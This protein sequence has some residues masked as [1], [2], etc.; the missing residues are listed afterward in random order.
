MN[1]TTSF[2][3]A[4]VNALPLGDGRLY[5]GGYFSFINGQPREHVG[6]VNATNGAVD[7]WYPNGYT[8]AEAGARVD[9]LA[10]SGDVLY[11]GGTF[12]S[13]GAFQTSAVPRHY[14]AALD[15]TKDLGA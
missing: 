10:V 5:V 14:L 2:P 1:G 13:I 11:V 15:T 6:S 4:S 7:S 8:G 12:S 3:K 9:A